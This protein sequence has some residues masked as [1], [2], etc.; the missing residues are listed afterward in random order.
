LRYFIDWQKLFDALKQ[1]PPPDRLKALQGLK[2]SSRATRGK[3]PELTFGWTGGPLDSKERM[4]ESVKQMV[5]GFYQMYWSMMTSAPIEKPSEIQRIEPQPDGNVIAYLSSQSNKVDMTVDKEHL[6]IHYK[7]DT[8]ALK[9][10]IDLHYI[11]SPS[12]APGDLHR[13]NSLDESVQFGTSTMNVRVSLDYQ[14]VDGLNVPKH[15]AVQLVGAYSIEM[16]FSG[17]STATKTHVS[18]PK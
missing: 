10:L 1:T 4:E 6:P 13:L 12:P 7:L 18:D 8:P 11:P 5:G 2:V 3:V 9:A 15:A 17:C 16:E 14:T